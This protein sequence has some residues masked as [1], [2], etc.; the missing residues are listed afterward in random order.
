MDNLCEIY[1]VLETKYTKTISNV[2]IENLSR[3]VTSKEIESV[4]KNLIQILLIYFLKVEE[5]ETSPNSFHDSRIPIMPKSV[6]DTARKLT[7]DSNIIYEHACKNFNKILTY[8][9]H[10]H[11]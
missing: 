1:K 6:K 11:I 2:E 4:T 10:Q 8:R 5:T 7:T 3:P 9:I